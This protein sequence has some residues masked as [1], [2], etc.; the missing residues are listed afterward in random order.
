MDPLHG[1]RILLGVTGGIACYK[2][3]VL[4]RE[5]VRAGAQVTVAMTPAAMRFVQPLTFQ[6]LSGRP[7]M[8]DLFSL[9]QESHIGH[10][11][12]ADQTDLVVVAPCSADFIARLRAGMADDVLAA[13]LLATRAP[14]WLAPAMNDRMWENAAT[15][16][17]IRA[18]QARGL[19]IIP[20]ETGWLAEGREAV[21]RLADPVTIANCLRQ[22]LGQ[23]VLPLAGCKVLVSAGPTQEPLDPA[24]FLSNRSSGRMGYAIAQ[25]ARDLGAQVT[26]VRGAVHLPDPP[27]VT[28]VRVTTAED[29]AQAVLSRQSEQDMLILA[30]AVADYRPAAYSPAKIKRQ[31]RPTFSLELVANPDI[32]AQV[33]KVKRPGQILA[34]FAAESHDLAENAQQKLAAKNADVVAANPINEPDAGFDTPTNRLVLFFRPGPDGKAPPPETLPLQ[35]KEAL[36]QQLLLALVKLHA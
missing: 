32:A 8:T 4:L 11:Q 13:T 6:S 31:G 14:I 24:R 15:R 5:L 22:S 12:V 17:N 26:L 20:P 27:G 1:K 16:D 3:V 35:S 29:M 2:A 25:A 23:G 9:D 34:V 21:G 28:V 19:H 30:A 36:A 33:G 10:V 7:V 18:L